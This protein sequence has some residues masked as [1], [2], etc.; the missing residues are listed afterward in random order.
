[1]FP[2]IGVLAPEARRGGRPSQGRAYDTPKAD[3]RLSGFSL[4]R[5]HEPENCKSPRKSRL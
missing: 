2:Q 3:L 1:M 5:R 4:A